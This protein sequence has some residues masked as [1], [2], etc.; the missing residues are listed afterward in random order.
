MDGGLYLVIPLSLQSF[1]RTL[2]TS[3]PSLSK[4]FISFYQQ[5]WAKAM[6]LFLLCSYFLRGS[7]IIIDVHHCSEHEDCGAH[8]G[9]FLI[10]FI[11]ANV[12]QSDWSECVASHICSFKRLKNF[13][14]CNELKIL[15]PSVSP[16]SFPFLSSSLFLCIH[17][18]WIF[19]KNFCFLLS[20]V[21]GANA[22]KT[23]H[24]NMDCLRYNMMQTLDHHC[25]SRYKTQ[26]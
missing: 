5:V 4:L 17:S 23:A 16:L 21:C 14:M 15:D 9:S 24:W 10:L 26:R 19:K 6:W 18:F 22:C 7:M 2:T 13:V 3:F 8:H 11:G 1:I 25:W 20:F 12:G